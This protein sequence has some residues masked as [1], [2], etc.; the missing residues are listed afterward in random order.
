MAT[1]NNGKYIAVRSTTKWADNIRMSRPKKLA[2]FLARTPKAITAEM[3]RYPSYAAFCNH[4]QKLKSQDSSTLSKN[5]M[6][7][8]FLVKVIFTRLWMIAK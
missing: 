2:D 1:A 6:V 8:T 3:Y 5:N 4:C 7:V